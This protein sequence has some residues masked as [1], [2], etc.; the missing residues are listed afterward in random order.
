LITRAKRSPQGLP[1]PAIEGI[2]LPRDDGRIV[3]NPPR[4]MLENM[5]ELP[6]VAPIYRRDLNID[7]YFI[8]YLLHP[9]VSILHRPGLPLEV[10]LLPLA[11]DSRRPPLSSSFGRST[12]S[13][14]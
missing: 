6:F 5:D 11:A 10:H 8:G 3:H 12:S 4:P 7:N 2:V 9:Y 1:L 13:P 14:K